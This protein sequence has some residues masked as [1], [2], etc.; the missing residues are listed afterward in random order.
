MCAIAG[1]FGGSFP[2]LLEVE[3]MTA[4]M[5][6]RGPDGYGHSI[7]S[8]GGDFRCDAFNA[9][10]KPEYPEQ[11]KIALGHRRLAILDLSSAGLQPMSKPDMKL[12][13]V[14]NGEIY[15]YIEL[16]DE[17]RA[18]GYS[19][20]TD[21]DTEVALMAYEHWGV[22]CFE[23]LIGMW[24]MAIYDGRKQ[25]LV[26]SRDR[27]GI[28]PLYYAVNKGAFYF[29][30]E[31]KA[32]VALPSFVK[33][34]N[35]SAVKSF[36]ER[37]ALDHGST[38]F[39]EN[40][41]SFPAACYAEIFADSPTEIGGFTPYFELSPTEEIRTEADFVEEFRARF[42]DSVSLHSRS[43]VPIGS[44]LSGG[45]DSTG[46]VCGMNHLIGAEANYSRM[47]FG[48]CSSDEEWNEKRWMEIA[49][50]SAN[51]ELTHVYVNQHDFANDL[52]QIVWHA[53]EPF[54]SASVVA[55]WFVFKAAKKAG[56][57]VMLDGQGADEVLGGY[58]GYFD[59][60]TKRLLQQAKYAE[61]L[62]TL[63][64]YEKEVGSFPGRA[65]IR[66]HLSNKFGA[67][68]GL[69]SRLRKTTRQHRNAAGSL[70]SLS[71]V[72]VRD[73]AAADDA[74]SA[75][76][77]PANT[78][79]EQLLADVTQDVLPQLLRNE[80]RNS[81]AH[82]IEARVPFLDHRLVEFAFRLPDSLKIRGS[83]TKLVLRKALS[84]IVPDEILNRQDKIG[85]KSTP[86]WTFSSQTLE[87]FNLLRND[88]EYEREWFDES[89][90]Q[91]AFRLHDHSVN[92]EF[93]LWR[94]IN[95][96][97]WLRTHWA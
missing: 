29:A 40:V 17:L 68:A 26:L 84:G 32:I 75:T 79:S 76:G 90:L 65:A 62:S 49:A 78:L 74:N 57:T 18:L 30:S 41:F 55:Q 67:V 24:A 69:L 50:R 27:F 56:V 77:S 86:Q 71:S 44:C 11:S 33:S 14:L 66:S 87:A 21:T 6:H 52:N 22:R 36:I 35:E 96:K 61:V 88:T 34:P 80:D 54:G 8:S 97:L 12:S 59:V 1:I 13:I 3:R 16:R 7:W 25:R 48:F 53:D 64:A 91:D 4:A 92:A 70:P 47:A 58:H 82:S 5:S 94:I 23:R 45:L 72:M 28:K 89:A 73:L 15:N 93:L 43:D 81:M 38:T 9:P 63:R 95:L 51:V 20:R 10:L 19:F 37:G 46:I 60:V 2:E 85:F 39:F 42:L 83:T 31:I